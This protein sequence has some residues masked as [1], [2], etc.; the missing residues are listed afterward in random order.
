MVKIIYKKKQSLNDMAKGEGG[1]GEEGEEVEASSALCL[2]IIASN[3]FTGV[4]LI[5]SASL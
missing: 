4:R 5:K 1:E 3:F 2:I